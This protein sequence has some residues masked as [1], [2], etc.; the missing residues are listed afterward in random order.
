MNHSEQEDYG[1]VSDHIDDSNKLQRAYRAGQRAYFSGA[2]NPH[3]YG[4]DEYNAWQNGIQWEK[5]N[6]ND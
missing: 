6:D 3:E 5:E 2:F 1:D 4:T